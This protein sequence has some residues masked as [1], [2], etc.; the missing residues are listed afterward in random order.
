M[1]NAL[2]YIFYNAKYI[3]P[4]QQ[5]V[6]EEGCTCQ[7]ARKTTFLGTFRNSVIRVV[8][9]VRLQADYTKLGTINFQQMVLWTFVEVAESLKYNR[10]VDLHFVRL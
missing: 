4:S 6:T 1:L 10:T 8:M 7:V 9:S 2:D 3:C 5:S